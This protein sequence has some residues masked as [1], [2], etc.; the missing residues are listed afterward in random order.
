MKNLTE[1]AIDRQ[2]VLNNKLALN[3]IQ[4]QVGL[5]GMFF[6]DEYKFTTSNTPFFLC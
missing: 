3:K 6:K 5:V 2:N 1:S 4:E